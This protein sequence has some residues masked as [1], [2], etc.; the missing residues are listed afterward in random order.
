MTTS[1]RKRQQKQDL[2]V[3][4]PRA[5]GVD[6]GSQFHIVAVPADCDTEP[7]RSFRSFTNLPNGS[8]KSV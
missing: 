6:I 5:A 2:P 4:H 7:V 8:N 3:V 1:K